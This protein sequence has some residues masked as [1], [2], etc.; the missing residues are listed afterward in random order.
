MLTGRSTTH[1]ARRL[2]PLATQ[3]DCLTQPK[4][5]AGELRREA[6]STSPG[7]RLAGR[8]HVAARIRESRGKFVL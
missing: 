7:L 6:L 2:L 5:A 1:K 4:D 3:C 8:Q